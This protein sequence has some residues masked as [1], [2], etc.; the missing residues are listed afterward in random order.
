MP[1]AIPS[2][3]L[4]LLALSRPLRSS[5]ACLRWWTITVLSTSRL[6]NLHTL[7]LLADLRGTAVLILAAPLGLDHH[8]GQVHPGRDQPLCRTLPEA[9]GDL[10]RVVTQPW[11]AR[12]A[13][14]GVRHG[15]LPEWRAEPL[16][17]G[18]GIP[19]AGVHALIQ[20]GDRVEDTWQW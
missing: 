13:D 7:T 16:E 10:S 4:L 3:L 1:C 9:G 19:G 8:P 14:A 5:R 17:G 18:E 20:A 11:A 2:S 12:Q 6:A 15:R